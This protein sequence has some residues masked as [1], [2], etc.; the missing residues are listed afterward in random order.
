[1]P[2]G[3]IMRLDFFL[4]VS[5]LVHRR[6]VAKELCDA[7][8]VLLNHRVAKASAEVAPGQWL[9]IA[10]GGR[11]REVEIMAVPAGRISRKGSADLYRLARETVEPDV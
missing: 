10:S 1:M 9:S 2:G 11:I 5:R 7:G 6:T 4:K 8:A 3:G